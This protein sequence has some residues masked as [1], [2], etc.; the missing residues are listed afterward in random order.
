MSLLCFAN[1]LSA[2]I[3]P[4][5]LEVKTEAYT[6]LDNPTLLSDT[7]EGWDDPDIIIPLGFEFEFFGET[8]DT[9]YLISDFIGP[10]LSPYFELDEVPQKSFYPFFI[11]NGLD[12]ADRGLNS[13]TTISPIS[14]QLTGDPGSRI[15]KLEYRNA[16]FL[17]NIDYGG[18]VDSTN[19]QIWL[20]EGSNDIEIHFGPSSVTDPAIFDTDEFGALWIGF[21]GYQNE[22]ESDTIDLL[23]LQG[24]AEN[25]TIAV[26]TDID[27]E[28]GE[29]ILTKE[30]FLQGYPADGQVYR[31]TSKEIV[32][33]KEIND[34]P[35]AGVTP[36]LVRDYFQVNMTGMNI[37]PMDQ[38][39]VYDLSGRRVY[40]AQLGQDT[41]RVSTGDW[42]S[43]TYFLRMRIGD[44]LYK[45]KIAKF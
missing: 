20:Y 1:V 38:L 28:N 29:D 30:L 27:L 40:T 23:S 10:H 21:F 41:H 19:M 15:G 37:S 45:A 18:A 25:P 39:E 26:T 12:L 13:N 2:Q 14:Y 44:E 6:Y 33:T 5:D 17:E 8:L 31:F 43:G 22:I 42:H 16:G 4:Y 9:F 7:L 24:S 36:R 34:L 32:S 35:L 3:F 11:A